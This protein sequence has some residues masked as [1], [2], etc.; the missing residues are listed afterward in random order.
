MNIYHGKELEV[1]RVKRKQQQLRATRRYYMKNLGRLLIL[2][3][4]AFSICYGVMS[5]HLYSELR[6]NI[7]ENDNIPY[8]VKDE[9]L[10]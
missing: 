8:Y 2:F 9:L 7:R 6:E 5:S 1:S 10:R 3:I 4:T